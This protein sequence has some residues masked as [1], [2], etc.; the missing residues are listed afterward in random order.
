MTTIQKSVKYLKV[1]DIRHLNAR[2]FILELSTGEPLP[3]MLPG[4]FVQ[5][6]VEGSPAT[7]LRR[8]FSI[9]S[10]FRSREKVPAVSAF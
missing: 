9:H 8:P 4:N 7:F 6:L 3:M 5:V 10:L 2:H 1:S